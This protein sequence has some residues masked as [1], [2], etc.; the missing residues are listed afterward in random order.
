MPFFDI[1]SLNVRF[2]GLQVLQD[3]DLVINH[4]EIAGLIGP[5]G[6]GKTTLFNCISGTQRPNSGRVIFNGR[7]VGGLAPH[8]RSRL[9]I[10]R[11]FQTVKVFGAL[12]VRENVL[13]GCHTSMR[14]GVFSDGLHLPRSRAAQHAAQDVVDEILDFLGLRTIDHRLAGELPLGQQ[15][16]VEIGRALATRP[17]LLLLD[18][19]TSG[20]TSAETS[21]LASLL[22]TVRSRY[23]LSLLVVEHDIA[24]VMSLCDF[25][26]VL[27]F[28]RII[29]SGTPAEVRA[30]PHVVE[31]YLGR[32]DQDADPQ[33]H[34]AEAQLVVS[35]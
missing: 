15:R 25:V 26:Y 34:D 28:G 29:A 14:T 3:V 19:A 31:A 18:E 20:I 1:R 9:G 33:L 16:L 27:D 7:D 2:G 30:N 21:E 5:N 24:L 10:G 23:Q 13:I 8:A 11:T 6:A 4:S 35:A 32:V 17:R 22:R 12:S